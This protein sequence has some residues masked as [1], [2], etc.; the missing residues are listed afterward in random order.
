MA[1]TARRQLD[2]AGNQFMPMNVE[3]GSWDEH[4]MSTKKLVAIGAL[5]FVLLFLIMTFADQGTPVGSILLIMAVYLLVAQWVFRYIVF[6]ERF[7]YKMYKVMKDHEVTT[8]AIFWGIASIRDSYDGAIMTYSDTKIGI[9]VRLERDTIT[10]KSPDFKE[11]HYDAISDFYRELIL[12]KYRFVQMNVMEQ[13]GND[14]RLDE[15]NKLV[16]K[17]SNRN[18]CDL[19]EKS[20]GYIKNISHRTLYESDYFLIYT[21]DLQKIDSI[22]DDSIECLYKILDGAYIGYR[23]LS[24]REIIEFVKEVYGVKYFNYTQATLDMFKLSGANT[25]KPFAISGIEYADGSFQ[26]IESYELNKI[27]QMA[28]DVL[29]GA[30][31]IEDISIMDT[32]KRDERKNNIEIDLSKISEGYTSEREIPIPNAGRPSKRIGKFGQHNRQQSQQYQQGQYEGQDQMF[33]DGYYQD[34]WAM[35]V[36]SDD[37]DNTTIDF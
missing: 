32:L 26:D 20:I 21:T 34:P 28:S 13:A 19:M 4:F 25:K 33:Q 22:I 35:D 37:S 24:A 6:E 12:N 29:S 36:D 14:P 23:V 3:G 27:Y 8:P 11:I 10:G 1:N 31:R 15:L 5:F 7:Y 9:L 16:H 2:S 18:I 17:S 30:R